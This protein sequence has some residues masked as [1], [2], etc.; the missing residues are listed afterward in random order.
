[1]DYICN[2]LGITLEHQEW[3]KKIQVPFFILARYQIECILLDHVKTLFLYPK[4]ELDQIVT[5]KK[6]ILRIQRIEK[7][8]VVLILDKMTR[9]R[10][11]YFLDAHI[12]F[13]VENKQIYLPFLGV[14]LQERFDTENVLTVKLQPSAQVLFFYYIYKNENRLYMNE[15][16]RVLGFSAMTITRAMR[17]LVQTGIFSSKKDG[18]QKVLYAT[19][20]RKELYQ[21]MKPFLISPVRRR[22]YIAK[23]ER[24]QKMVLS[25]NTA[26]SAMRMLNPPRLNCYAIESNA[27]KELQGTK[28]LLNGENQVC[29]ELWKY[30]PQILTDNDRVDSL[31]LALSF[32]DEKDERVEEAVEEVL[33]GLW[34]KLDDSRV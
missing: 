7:L 16:I 31:S 4:T 32:I 17:Q 10:R 24:T 13:V 26:L 2:T 27:V 12:P 34:R 28:M 14:F 22:I 30:D 21:K 15:A 19:A 9:Q 8:P 1:M 29:V 3:D 33:N 6:H 18:V 25:G 5:V 20:K 23:E 11:Q